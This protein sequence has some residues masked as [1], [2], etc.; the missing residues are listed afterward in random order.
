MLI[1]WLPVL[2]YDLQLLLCL[3]VLGKGA[4]QLAVYSAH[5]AIFSS[6]SRAAGKIA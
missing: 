2:N 5:D 1:E 4:Y 6:T 3:I